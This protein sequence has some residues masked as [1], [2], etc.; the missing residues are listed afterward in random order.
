MKLR[1]NRTVAVCAPFGAHHGA[2]APAAGDELELDDAFAQGGFGAVHP[3]RSLAGRAPARRIVAK[4]FD[5]DA[6]AAGGGAQPVINSTKDLHDA[7]VQNGPPG[8]PDALLALAY[9]LGEVA[10]KG[11]PTLVALMLDLREAGHEEPPFADVR[12]VPAYLQRPPRDRIE[13]ALRFAERAMLLETV[14][15]LHGDLNPEN[16]LVHPTTGDVQIIDFDAGV[17]VKTPSDRPRTAG[18]PDDCMPP[19]VKIVGR[20]AG[21]DLNL[22]TREAERWSIGSLVGYCLFGAH[23]GFFL[24]TISSKAISGYAKEPGGWPEID[25]NGPLF[26]KVAQNQ[27]AYLRMRGELQALP[28]AALDAF[29]KFFAAG[30]DGARRPTAADWHAALSALREKPKLDIVDVD[31]LFVVEGGAV[32]VNWVHPQRHPRGARPGRPAAGQR[33]PAR[34]DQRPDVHPRDR[35]QRLRAGERRRAGGAR[36]G[37]APPGPRARAGVPGPHVHRHRGA[38][39]GPGRRA[40]AA[41]PR[42]RRAVPGA[43]GERISAA[44]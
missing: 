25:V 7:L 34:A 33:Q 3:V 43:V 39:R 2:P 37:A 23:P 44:T 13:I 10:V 41:G 21:V 36:G 19:E 6:L 28:T 15:L 8:W 40:H 9:A 32:T 18:K 27:R 14:G 17:I 42:P 26:T 29:V 4:L 30:L 31:H 22:Y 16:L 11:R 35:V 12:N 1:V 38:P 24:R 5:P 20:G